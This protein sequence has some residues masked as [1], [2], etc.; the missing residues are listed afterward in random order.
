MHLPLWPLEVVVYTHGMDI[1]R[2]KHP[3]ADLQLMYSLKKFPRVFRRL[4]MIG[5]LA[6]EKGQLLIGWWRGT[7]YGTRESLGQCP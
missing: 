7:T 4:A 1:A 2:C 3:I 6:S 5:S